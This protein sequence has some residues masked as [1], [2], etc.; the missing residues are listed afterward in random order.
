VTAQLNQ[1]QGEIAKVDEKAEAVLERT[2]I[3]GFD[4]SDSPSS[5]HD[6]SHRLDLG[7]RPLANLSLELLF[8]IHRLL[9]PDSLIPDPFA[10]QLRPVAVTA[11][12]YAAPDPGLV[13]DLVREFIG[14]WRDFYRDL[15]ASDKGE[16]VAALAQLHHR[17]VS[18]HPFLDG[19][20]R[21]G[22]ALID[23][24]ARELLGRPIGPALTADPEHYFAALRQ[25]DEGDLE[26]LCA[27][28]EASLAGDA[29]VE[30]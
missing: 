12:A 13:P 11:G 21:V 14:W 1:M 26:P 10:S 20:G 17:F 22:R 15:V 5:L 8:L 3:A 24:A 19:N 25:G 27:L 4:G 30:W 23:Q 6:S 9:V 28:I 2:M 18:I 29:S 16:V 7:E